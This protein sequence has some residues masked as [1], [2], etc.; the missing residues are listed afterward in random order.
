[1]LKAAWSSS[2]PVQHSAAKHNGEGWGG[3][4][5][6]AYSELTPSLMATSSESSLLEHSAEI[7]EIDARLTALQAFMK[8]S[9]ETTK[10]FAKR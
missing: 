5:L 9:L 3:G 2:S 4:Q 1:M 8:R 10:H 6:C 7:S